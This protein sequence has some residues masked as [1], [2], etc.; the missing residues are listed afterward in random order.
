MRQRR[1]WFVVTNW[2]LDA[3]S[4][5]AGSCCSPAERGIAELSEKGST[6]V[7]LVGLVALWAGLEEKGRIGALKHLWT[8]FLLKNK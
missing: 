5:W 1:A 3:G 2:I 6:S 7:G 4:K 8:K